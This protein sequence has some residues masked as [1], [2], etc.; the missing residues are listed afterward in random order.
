M[1]NM[2]NLSTTCVAAPTPKTPLS[3]VTRLGTKQNEATRHRCTSVPWTSLSSAICTVA[4][5]SG[6]VHGRKNALSSR[7]QAL[8][9]CPLIRGCWASTSTALLTVPP[10]KL[11]HRFIP[12][13]GQLFN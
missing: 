2:L 6:A 4:I 3:H 9:S 10:L 12:E 1:F 8:H 11:D 5:A 7:L 13:A